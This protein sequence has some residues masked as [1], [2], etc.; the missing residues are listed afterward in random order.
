M[1]KDTG[2]YWD[3]AAVADYLGIK[4]QSVPMW[5]KRNGVRKRASAS[6]VMLA[7]G[8]TPGQGRRTDIQPNEE[9]TVNRRDE[10]LALWKASRRTPI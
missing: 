7:N 8:E 9:Q 2:E 5:L 4:P 6:E 3:D 1:I 10:E